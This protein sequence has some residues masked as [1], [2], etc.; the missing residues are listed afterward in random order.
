[1]IKIQNVKAYCCEDI[2]LIENYDKAI[3]DIT[4]SWD[5]H[6]RGEILP[7]GRYEAKDL[8]KCGLYWKRP[9]SELIFLSH[10]DHA[11]LHWKGTIRGTFSEEHKQHISEATK[12]A[13]YRPEVREKYL[14]GMKNRLLSDEDKKAIENRHNKV[15]SEEHKQK[16][17]KK[18]LQYDLNGNLIAEFKS[19]G[20]A[21]ASMGLKSQAN[22]CIAMKNGV[23][24]R[25]FIWKYACK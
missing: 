8:K 1:M 3:A 9:A 17:C 16:L 5:C 14:N 19:Q 24:Y 22:L 2:S 25:N 18:I 13:M 23:P 11:G 12:K 15:L 10:K 6:H 7:C 21:A 20:E 4:Q